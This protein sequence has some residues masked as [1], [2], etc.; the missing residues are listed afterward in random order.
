MRLFFLGL[1]FFFCAQVHASHVIGADI[2]YTHKGNK[3]YHVVY[4]L[5]RECSGI[6][7]QNVQFLI[8]K[9]DGTSAISISPNRT[10]I[11][12][13]SV[14][15]KND[16]LPCKPQNTTTNSGVEC[17][18]YEI[19]LDLKQSNYASVV[20]NNCQVLFAM[21]ICCRTGAITTLVPDNMYIESMVDLCLAGNKGNTSPRFGFN[22]INSV[23]CNNYILYNVG[24]I[25]DT[26]I[27]SLGFRSVP[28]LKNFNDSTLYS[29]SYSARIPMTPYC[30]PNPG[31][32][33][34]KALPGAKPPRGFYFNTYNGDITFTPSKCDEVGVIVM[35]V[36][37]WRKDS[38]GVLR[39]VGYIKRESTWFVRTCSENNAPYLAGNN[40]Y[41]VCEGS[42]ICFT[43]SSMD[44]QFL[45]KQLS[46][47]TLQLYWDSGIK[48]A[49]FRIIDPMAREKQA[50]FCWQTKIGDAKIAPYRFTVQVDDQHCSPPLKSFKTYTVQVKPKAKDHLTYQYLFKGGL[51]IIAN[52]SDSTVKSSYRYVNALYNDTMKLLHYGLNKTNDTIVFT[53]P[54]TY[55]LEH[56]VN[57]VP[58]NCPSTYY[59][60]LVITQA[61]ITTINTLHTN[62]IRLFP[63][64]SSGELS[65]DL[66]NSGFDA[67]DYIVFDING[68]PIQT[69]Q[70]NAANSTISQLPQGQF[71][72]RLQKGNWVEQKQIIVA[73]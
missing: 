61:H 43:V 22:P 24:A 40:Q 30:P 15:C 60:T 25:E 47:D 36:D 18:T 32:I 23:C 70:I 53:S 12:D 11:K 63:L 7:L 31:V 66:S 39:R 50:E 2:T 44:D 20:A 54:G 41:A 37:E 4:S 46:P 56:Q 29:G 42:K 19:D 49:T 64:P 28:A 45:P 71:I 72:L 59:D 10:S 52:P 6:P 38:L 69:G 65:V 26:D 17:H 73:Y 68:K 58:Y 14:V 34:C 3:V 57:Q 33:N 21:S 27:D 62:V 67:V 55:I 16:T 5:Y 1:F 51:V 35:Q 48:M 9:G 13:I 8:S